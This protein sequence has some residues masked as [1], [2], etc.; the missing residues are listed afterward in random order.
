[1]AY[2]PGNGVNEIL[3]KVQTALRMKSG[4]FDTDI[5]DLIAAAVLDLET[6][7]IPVIFDDSNS[8]DPLL[9]QAIK[10]YCRSYFGEGENAERYLRCYD[11]LKS[12][13]MLSGEYNGS[14]IT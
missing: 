5:N 9:T 3:T 12:S 11:M 7:G 10:L 14:S 6:A 8:C 4:A 1:M 2:I 13:L